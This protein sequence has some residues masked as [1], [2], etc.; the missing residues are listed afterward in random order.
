MAMDDLQDL[1]LELAIG[2]H[3]LVICGQTGVG[4]S[5]TY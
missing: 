4:A 5:P 3:N 2:C 1:C